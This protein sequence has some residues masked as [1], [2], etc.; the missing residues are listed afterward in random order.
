MKFMGETAIAAFSA[1]NA[2][3]GPVLTAP[4]GCLT[5]PTDSDWP[6][7]E[8]WK[9]Q[10]PGVIPRDEKNSD[11]PNYR[12]RPKYASDV[13]KAVKFAG[14]NNIRVSIVVSGH[15]IYSAPMTSLS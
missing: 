7:P 9:A 4:A 10:L 5:L 13:Q 2:F 14:D 8:V 12:I 1:A 11:Q 15:G 6:A 3:A